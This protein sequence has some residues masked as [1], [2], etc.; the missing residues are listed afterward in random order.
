MKIIKQLLSIRFCL[1]LLLGL[2]IVSTPATAADDELGFS[3][4]YAGFLFSDSE[5]ESEAS[6]GRSSTSWGHI[7]G[8]GGYVLND[9]V[10][11]EGQ[12]GMT[13]NTDQDKGILTYGAYARIGKDLGQY[14]PYFLL[15]FAGFSAYED[16]D[17]NSESSVSYGVGL[18]IFGSKNLAV[19]LEYVN[20]YHDTVDDI[21]DTFDMVG[22][23]FTYYFVEDKSYFN[24]N[25]NKIRSIRY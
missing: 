16:E 22:L 12:L 11:L 2:S 9:L 18:E 5:Y 19:T 17:E 15:G 3:G 14:K 10:S 25:R 20:L 8:K 6:F 7:K 1:P 21:E 23:G 24:K 4:W 13:T